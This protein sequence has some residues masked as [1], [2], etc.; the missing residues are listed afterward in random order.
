M[1]YPH[2]TDEKTKA[3]EGKSKVTQLTQNSNLCW[4]D[5]EVCAPNLEHDCQKYSASLLL[6]VKGA[7]YLES[8]ALGKAIAAAL[9]HICG[10]AWAFSCLLTLTARP[11]PSYRVE[12]SL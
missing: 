4:C 12:H 5:F 1:Y 9:T 6:L 10:L 3:G 2:F 8:L 11:I 7:H